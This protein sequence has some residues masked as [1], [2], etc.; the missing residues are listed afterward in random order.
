MRKCRVCK[1]RKEVLWSW[2][3]LGP[4]ELPRETFT[5]PGCHYRGF[6]VIPICDGCKDKVQAGEAVQF[7]YKSITYTCIDDEMVFGT[8]RVTEYIPKER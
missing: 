5:I 3:P 8:R 2:Q 4:A 7:D 1:Q 6:A